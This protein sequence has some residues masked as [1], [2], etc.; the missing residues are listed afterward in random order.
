MIMSTPANQPVG[1]PAPVKTAAEAAAL[2]AHFMG[3]MDQLIATVQRETELVR[4]GKLGAASQLGQEKAEL[5][6]LYIADM[7]RL[8]ASQ[9]QL[10]RVAPGTLATV[11]ERHDTFRA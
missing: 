3:V 2:V 7:L 1:V 6:R 11:R 5:T 4:A 9:P 10:A 8:R